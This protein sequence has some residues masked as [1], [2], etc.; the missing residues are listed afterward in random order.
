MR[1]PSLGLMAQ[2]GE[3]RNDRSVVT[4][5]RRHHICERF[6]SRCGWERVVGSTEMLAWKRT[7]DPH[8]P[9]FTPRVYEPP[10]PPVPKVPKVPKLSALRNSSWYR[11]FQRWL[12]KNASR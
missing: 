11:D 7:H 5:R 4:Y 9:H 3:I 10:E 2:H 12:Q 6:C 1:Q 8:D